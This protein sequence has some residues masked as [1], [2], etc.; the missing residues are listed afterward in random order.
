MRAR[1]RELQAVELRKAGFNYRQIGELLGVSHVAAGKAVKRALKT[2]SEQ[3]KEATDDFRQLELERLDE[4][5]LAFWPKAVA[6]DIQAAKLILRV[7]EQRSRLLGLEAPRPLVAIDQRQVRFGDRLIPAE[8]T[9]LEPQKVELAK[10]LARMDPRKRA[11]LTRAVDG[12]EDPREV[13]ER[14]VI[15]A[16]TA[17]GS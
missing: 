12:G 10:A 14:L 1:E 15:D 8:Y 7:V 4:L 17:E 2:Y 9:P 6:G 13:L 11:M 16:E 3:T 5:N